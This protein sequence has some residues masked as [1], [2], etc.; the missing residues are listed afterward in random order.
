[1]RLRA[2]ITA[3]ASPGPPP[4]SRWTAA[5]Y[6]NSIMTFRI[7]SSYFDT[8]CIEVLANFAEHVS[9]TAFLALQQDHAHRIG[10]L[11]DEAPIFLRPTYQ[12][13][14]CA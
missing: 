1:M 8:C 13:F 6:V 5:L 14:D 11:S 10:F 3:A 4:V 12:A 2:S 9:S 7:F